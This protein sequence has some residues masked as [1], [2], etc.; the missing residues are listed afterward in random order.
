MEFK[1]VKEYSKRQRINLN[2][3]DGF[4]NGQ[5]VVV[6]T[7]GQ[8]EFRERT[9]K[10]KIDD[11]NTTIHNLKLQIESLQQDIDKLSVEN[12]LLN[13][14]QNNLKEIIEDVSEAMAK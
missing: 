3:S 6:L 14:Q 7:K 8:Y 1:Q 13:N 10:K 12:E 9:H 2:K 11:L 4:S 5:E